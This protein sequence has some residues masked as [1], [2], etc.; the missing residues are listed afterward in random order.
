MTHSQP[1]RHLRKSERTVENGWGYSPR[2]NITPILVE[3]VTVY[4]AAPA[5]R[6]VNASRTQ[7]AHAHLW[8]PRHRISAW[9]ACAPYIWDNRLHS[10][11]DGALALSDLYYQDSVR[12]RQLVIYPPPFLSSSPMCSACAPETT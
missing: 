1:P 10:L 11:D 7:E 12:S 9:Y 2:D 5:A 3:C 8:L 4:L 6:S